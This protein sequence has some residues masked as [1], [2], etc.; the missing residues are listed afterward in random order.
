[1]PLKTLIVERLVLSL[2]ISH[3]ERSALGSEANLSSSNIIQSQMIERFKFLIGSFGPMSL[4]DLLLQ[5]STP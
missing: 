1:M 4:L 5:N 3:P 2:C